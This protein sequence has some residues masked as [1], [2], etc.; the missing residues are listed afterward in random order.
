MA[1]TLVIAGMAELGAQ[2]ITFKQFF[3]VV[4]NWEMG[5]ENL[6]KKSSS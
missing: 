1:K 3:L 5:Y 2:Q 4:H 6:A